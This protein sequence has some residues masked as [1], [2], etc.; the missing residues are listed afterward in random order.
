[1]VRISKQQEKRNRRCPHAPRPPSPKTG[2]LKSP[3]SEGFKPH[4]N[5]I[6]GDKA[7]F[8]FIPK[9]NKKRV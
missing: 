2:P 5:A 8:C 3:F 1:M 6:T 9:I 4:A 7:A